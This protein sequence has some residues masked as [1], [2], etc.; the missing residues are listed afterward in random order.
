MKRIVHLIFSYKTGGAENLLMDIINEQVK[1]NEVFLIIINNLYE[2]YLVEKIDNRANIL[3][4]NRLQG[5]KSPY[6]V[7]KLNLILYRIK[8]DLIHCHQHNIIPMLFLYRE[9]TILT[10]HSL[11]IPIRNLGKYKKVFSISEAVKRDIIAR[12]GSETIV[13]T[14][15]INFNRFKL[16]ENNNN[17]S[18]TKRIVQVG[19]L[20]SEIKGQHIAINAIH[21]LNRYKGIDNLVLDI[22]GE[23]TPINSER[24]LKN[25]VKKLN[26]EKQVKFLGLKDRDFLYQNLCFYDLLIQP[27]LSEG[28]GLTIIEGVA[29][30]VPVLVSNIE[31]ALEVTNNGDLAFVFETNNEVSCAEKIYQVLFELDKKYIEDKSKRAYSLMKNKFSIEF[32]AQKYANSLNY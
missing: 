12:G 32:V 13:I 11:E 7:L 15:G 6:Y 24:L 14:N 3:Y 27:S 17:N 10:L 8:P 19:R 22:I 2:P 21:Y 9:K 20:D 26:L 28:F 31:S 23:G 16:K 25:L 1:T 4:L 29:S 5:S 18:T 30:N